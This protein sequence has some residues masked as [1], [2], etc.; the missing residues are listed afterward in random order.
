MKFLSFFNVPNGFRRITITVLATFPLSAC[1]TLPSSGPTGRQITKSVAAPESSIKLVE[2]EDIASLPVAPAHVADSLSNLEPPPT[3][4]VG[5]GD[6]LEITI[7]ESGVTLFGGGA[8]KIAPEGAAFD[9]SAK[10][11]KLP[12]TRVDDAGDI[13]LPYAGRLHVAGLTVG[14]IERKTRRCWCRCAKA[15]PTV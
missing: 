13:Q 14:A 5:P 1:A 6:V 11:E 2:L 9:P 8:A 4:M 10:S 15:S 3:D 7:Y 12:G